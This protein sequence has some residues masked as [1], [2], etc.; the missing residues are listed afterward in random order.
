LTL[1]IDSYF[2]Y[3]LGGK[4]LGASLTWN[5]AKDLPARSLLMMT[6]PLISLWIFIGISPIFENISFPFF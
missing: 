6:P 5:M 3:S 1:Y 2:L 4:G